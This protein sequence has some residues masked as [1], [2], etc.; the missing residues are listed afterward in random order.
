[1]SL[2]LSERELFNEGLGKHTIFFMISSTCVCNNLASLD[3]KFL[4]KKAIEMT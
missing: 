3:E 4:A 2:L 1:M